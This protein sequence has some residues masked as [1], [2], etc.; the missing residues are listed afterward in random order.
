MTVLFQLDK[1]EW[2]IIWISLCILTIAASLPLRFN[3][4]Q[5]FY[6][7][8]FNLFLGVVVDQL[9]SVPPYDLYDVL[10]PKFTFGDAFIYLFLYP[11]T[12]YIFLF[13]ADIIGFRKRLLLF[14]LLIG[15]S[16]L[17][18]FFEWF[19]SKYGVYK[20][21][22]WTYFLSGVSYPILYSLNL[23]VLYLI[24]YKNQSRNTKRN[25]L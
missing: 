6:I 21:K 4:P 16:L 12:V 9:L 18:L 2:L 8:V 11:P 24:K 13:L 5:I 23:L 17:T 1:G 19:L 10:S 3:V 14:N 7:F 15:W 22:G 25:H 20:Y